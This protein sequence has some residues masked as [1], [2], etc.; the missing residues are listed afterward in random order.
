[1]KSSPAVVRLAAA[2]AAIA[3]ADDASHH[4][5]FSL[6]ANGKAIFTLPRLTC[7]RE[8]L[9]NHSI[10][11]RVQLGVYLRLNDVPVPGLYGRSADE[12]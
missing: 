3:G 8:M 7:L 12:A 4:K 5:P 11:H 9:M 2:R 6:L 1:V 10:H